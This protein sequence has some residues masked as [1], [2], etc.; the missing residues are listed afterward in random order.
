MYISPV[1]YIQHNPLVADGLEGF[2]AFMAEMQAQ[3]NTMAYLRLHQVVGE[4]NFVL[5]MAEAT[6][7]GA[8]RAFYDL[9]R[10]DDGMIVEHWGIIAPMPG[11]D[12]PHNEAGKF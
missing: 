7:G 4:G 12:A 5:T 2:G 11:E 6:Q 10:L 9:F 1:T 8:P 3:G